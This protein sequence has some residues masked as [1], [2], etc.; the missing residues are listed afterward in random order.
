MKSVPLLILLL[1]LFAHPAICNTDCRCEN[2]VNR[3]G[4]CVDYV[5]HLIPNFPVPDDVESLIELKNKEVEKVAKGDVAI[6]DLGNYWHVAYVEKV[7]LDRQGKTT[8]IDVSEMNYGGPLTR[9]Q[10]KE[11]WGINSKKE[12][13]QAACCGVTKNFG[14]VTNRK[15]VDL[16][17]VRHIWTPKFSA[18]RMIGRLFR[19]VGLE[20]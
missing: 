17:T 19:S 11:K 6:F 8:A 9:R 2:W 5:H 1:L 20:L 18:Y 7:H 15:N 3:K 4:Y 16:T 13:Q 14:K 12:L 10:L